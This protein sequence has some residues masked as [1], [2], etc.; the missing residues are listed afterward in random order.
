VGSGQIAAQTVAYDQLVLNN[1]RSA[2]KLDEGIITMS[3]ITAGLYNGREVG[4]VIID[5]RAHPVAYTV[6]S[7][8]EG[9]DA[10]QFLSSI[11]SL[12]ETLNGVLSAS[13]NGRFSANGSASTIVRTLNGNVSVNL[14]EGKLAHVD[15]LHQLAAIGRFTRTARAVEP[16]TRLIR[17]NGDFEITN[18][19]ARTRNLEAVIE[20]GS[21]AAEGTVDL[22]DQKLDFRLTAVLSEDYSQ[23][24]GGIR[25]AGLMSTVLPNR[26]GEFV[27]PIRMTGTL[28]NPQFAPD[29]EK[30]A[31]MKLQ[32]LLPTLGNPDKLSTGILGEISRTKTEPEVTQPRVLPQ[33][34]DLLRDIFQG[35]FGGDRGQ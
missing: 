26:R 10:N 8:L 33:P 29:L 2:V 19:L 6:N 3:P 35:V 27:I 16:F 21:L 7:R 22:G 17:M 18:G 23:S 32:N 34:T 31:R 24:V 1:V 13:T 20:D 30:I 11:S 9:I 5:V 28:K 15:L 14:A 25:I 12:K 4:A